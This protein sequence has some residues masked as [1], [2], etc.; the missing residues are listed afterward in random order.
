MKAFHSHPLWP[1]VEEIAQRLHQAGH[2]AYLAGGCVRDALLERAINDFD[3][4]TSATPEQIEGLFERTI[5][6]GKAFGVIVV[7]A[8]N[9]QVEVATFRSDGSYQDG[10]HPNEVR[11]SSPEEDAKRRDFTVN[12]LFW[13]LKNH[14]VVDFVGGQEDLK[15]GVLRAIGLASERF[16]EDKLR[17]LRAVRFA[18]QLGFSIEDQTALAIRRWVKEIRVV[19]I[20]RIQVEL[21]KLLLS[22]HAILGIHYLELSG[23]CRELFPGSPER[24]TKLKLMESRQQSLELEEA[25]ARLIWVLMGNRGSVERNESEEFLK[26]FRFSKVFTNRISSLWSGLEG[27]LRYSELRLCDQKRLAAQ[28]TFELTLRFAEA[29]T[30]FDVIRLGEIEAAREVSL[31]GEGIPEPFLSGRDLIEIGLAPGAQMGDLLRELHNLQ[32]EGE[33]TSRAEALEWIK[34]EIAKA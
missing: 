22:D 4:A 17:M 8:T 7:P 25:W 12:G 1:E 3:V 24:L 29:L 33:I 32:I 10:R 18:A 26:N 11:F 30:R 31:K 34:R 2:E 19:S 15:L 28:E 23:L 6:V 13:D 21:S 5:D 20:E 9:G 14:K 16:K 27:L